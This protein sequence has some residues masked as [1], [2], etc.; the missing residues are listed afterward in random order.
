MR[1]KCQPDSNR[2]LDNGPSICICWCYVRLELKSNMF[3]FS[4]SKDLHTKLLCHFNLIQINFNSSNDTFSLRSTFLRNV[5]F[6]NKPFSN[7][8]NWVEIWLKTETDKWIVSCTEC[9]LKCMKLLTDCRY[10]DWEI[11][12]TLDN[13][14][15]AKGW[16]QTDLLTWSLQIY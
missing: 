10:H 2:V 3:V 8:W 15:I 6:S 9:M 7:K 16:S 11:P 5:T 12:H 1:S 13:E 14:N 4:I